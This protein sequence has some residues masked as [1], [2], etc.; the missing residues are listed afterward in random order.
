[1]AAADAD[2]A[3]PISEAPFDP[4][5]SRTDGGR[6]VR[7]QHVTDPG[8]SSR[9]EAHRLVWRRA[10]VGSGQLEDVAQAPAVDVAPL[11][12]V[13]RH[14]QGPPVDIIVSRGD[15]R[16]L[17]LHRV[18]DVLKVEEGHQA[19]AGGGQSPADQS[20]AVAAED[21]G[22]EGGAARGLVRFVTEIRRGLIVTLP[23]VLIVP[24]SQH[25][26]R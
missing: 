21:D 16:K 14:D 10:A 4:E 5:A 18:G 12:D 9:H 6:G 22:R 23:L 7:D 26:S 24:S 20:T 13:A 2:I 8:F 3:P 19:R 11:R 15:V 25:P 17:D 1:M